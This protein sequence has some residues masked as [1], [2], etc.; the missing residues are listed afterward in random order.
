MILPV[1][2]FYVHRYRWLFGS[3]AAL[4]GVLAILAQLPRG[5]GFDVV[6]N[7]VI[8]PSM[9][10]FFG[11]I[12]AFANPEADLTAESSGYP[13]FLLRMPVR[14]LSLALWPMLA[15]AAWATFVWLGFALGFARV[16]DP[17]FPIW[18]PVTAVVAI[19][20][21]FQAAIWMP[22]RYG[23]IRLLFCVVIPLA[24]VALALSATT[25]SW[26]HPAQVSAAF[27][28]LAS[29]AAAFALIGVQRAR[30][31]A[32]PRRV[33][34]ES[35][36]H[37]SL[38]SFSDPVAA[39]TWVDWR[40]Q[41]RFLPL[42]TA[43]VLALFTLPLFFQTLNAP[44]SLRPDSNPTEIYA[45]PYQLSAYWCLIWV[46]IVVSAVVGFGALRSYMRGFGGQYDLF[47]STRPL[48][49]DQILKAKYRSITKSVGWTVVVVVGYALFWALFPAERRI[50]SLGRGTVVERMPLIVF[51]LQPAFFM[52]WVNALG[53]L[54]LCAVWSWRNYAVGVA[55]D[56]TPLPSARGLYAT[57]AC[58]S[59]GAIWTVLMTNSQNFVT[60]TYPVAILAFLMVAAILKLGLSGYFA[61][62]VLTLRPDARMAI[63]VNVTIWIAGSLLC[64]AVFVPFLLSL[65]IGEYFK[66]MLVPFGGPL[67][68]M[69]LVPL[70]RP[71]GAR[72]AIETGRHR[73]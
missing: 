54:L 11:S 2:R 8:A 36:A 23:P 68:A 45:N 62:R 1:L 42:I 22:V 18:W 59:L 46:P 30:V 10:I 4:L 64:V 65:N 12:A 31:T 19:G 39:Q 17:E 73:G 26:W 15:S 70:A 24:M 51:L 28:A 13:R 48:T 40:K 58:A 21:T 38:T 49:T 16:L 47:F 69:L 5:P 41:A 44:I 63:T 60:E 9:L 14:T 71:I 27:I 53:L 29:A 55:A 67:L 66:A 61:S 56:L 43:A 50:D 72:L 35:T 34:T 52:V 20:L 32:V 3:V 37:R 57:I 6:R 33:P 7:V 25:S